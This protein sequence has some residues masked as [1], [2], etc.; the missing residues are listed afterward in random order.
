MSET[1]TTEVVSTDRSPLQEGASSAPK[2]PP[3]WNA[4]HTDDGAVLEVALP[5]VSKDQLKLE[6]GNRSLRL[7]A[8]RREGPGNARL[9]RGCQWP[10]GYELELRL[11]DS[12]DGTESTA[13]LEDGVLTV[14]IPLA[15]ASKPRRIEVV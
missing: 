6:I 14:T 2:I 9:I 15:E 4:R 7:D 12:L 13:K 8:S 1:S 5:G 3:L 10:A 11:D